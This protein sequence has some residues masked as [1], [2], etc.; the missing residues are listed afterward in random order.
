MRRMAVILAIVGVLVGGTLT[1]RA[2]SG[3]V[4]EPRDEPSVT[5]RG[6]YIDCVGERYCYPTTTDRVGPPYT[7][8]PDGPR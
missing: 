1:F 3:P 6:A 4:A 2:L 8:P 7:G 5:R